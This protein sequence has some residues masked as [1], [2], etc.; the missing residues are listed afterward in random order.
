MKLWFDCE[1]QKIVNQDELVCEYD[2][3]LKEME[4]ENGLR[5]MIANHEDFTFEAFITNCTTAWNGTLIPIY[6]AENYVRR[7]DT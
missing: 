5:Y 3:W 2:S 4:A 7:C 1:S 6:N